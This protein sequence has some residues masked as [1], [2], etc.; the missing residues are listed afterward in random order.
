MSDPTP[1]GDVSPS[2]APPSDPTPTGQPTYEIPQP[3]ARKILPK[4]FGFM[5]N[6]TFIQGTFYQEGHQANCLGL[7]GDKEYQD[8]NSLV[9]LGN[10]GA[11]SQDIVSKIQGYFRP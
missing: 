10:F 4:S 3:P 11:A 6:G 9:T 5:H 2:G 7:Y 8:L 1:N